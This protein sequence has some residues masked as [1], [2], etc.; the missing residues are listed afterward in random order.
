MKEIYVRTKLVNGTYMYAPKGTKD[1]YG[2]V[3]IDNDT[4]KYD[5]NNKLKVNVSV[6]NQEVN[7]E[8]QNEIDK[9]L[10]KTAVVQT[11]GDSTDKVM[12]QKAATDNF[13][14]LVNGKVPASQLPSYVDDVVEYDSKSAFPAEGETGKIYVDKSTNLTYRWSNSN[15]Y[16]MIGG[17]DLNLENGTG[18]GSLVQKRLKSDGVTWTT[19]KAYQGAGAAF[20]GNTQSGRTEEEFN[21]YFWDSTKN[22]ALNGGKGKDSNGNILDSNGLTYAKSYSYALAEGE[23]TKA[24]GRSSHAEGNATQ[25]IGDHSHSEGL[26]TKAEG[27]AAHTEGA[28]TEAYYTGSHAEGNHTKTYA[29]YQH[30]GGT[31]NHYNI[32]ALYQ[33]GN[34][35][36]DNDRKNAFEVLKDGRAKVYGTPQ[37]PTD[38]VRKQ[39]LDKAKDDFN[40]KNGTGTKSVEQV[41][42]NGTTTIPISTK[43]PNA[44]TLGAPESVNIGAVGEST[45]VFGGASNATGK[46][47]HAEGTNTVAIGKY[48]HAEGDNSVALGN[49]SHAE[50]ITTVAK[51]QASHSEGSTTQSIGDHSHAEGSETISSGYSSHS[52]GGNTQASG[53]TAHAEGSNTIASGAASHAEGSST[54]ATIDQAHAEG[55]ETKAS[56]T[57]SHSEGVS[58]TS[59]GDYSHAEGYKSTT[60]KTAYTLPSGTESG[61]GITGDAGDTGSSW[62]IEQHRGEGAHSEGILTQ[63]SGYSSHSEGVRTV[64]D[65]HYSHAE[66]QLTYAKGSSSHAEGLQTNAEGV[67]SHAEGSITKATGSSSHAEG[68]ETTASIDYAHAEGNVTVASGTASHAEG[69][70]TTASHVAAHAEGKYTEAKHEASHAEG[71]NTKTSRPSQH[72]EGKYNADNINALHIVGNGTSDTDRK[73]AF[74]V[75]TDGRAKVQSAPVESDDVVRKGDLSGVSKIYMHKIS[76][77][78]S[79]VKSGNFI[80]YSTNSTAYSSISSLPTM[81]VVGYINFPENKGVVKYNYFN[82]EPILSVSGVVFDSETNEYKFMSSISIMPTNIMDTVTEL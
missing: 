36:S 61:S 34:G 23:S 5:D 70:T 66:G 51:G 42:N 54:Q 44:V 37:E 2:T 33:V 17:G 30:V 76:F 13:A 59:E 64:A 35:T 74:T 15:N 75:L 18:T 55:L 31:Y 39:D 21:A 38:V 57:A 8:L 46:R 1:T 7:K 16:I 3:L 12:S 29:P 53:L 50:G 73:N 63:S 60:K 4:L 80:F 72:V 20:G 28:Y 79:S 40:L 19:A 67:A 10:D 47:S 56:G 22:V 32:N 62:N 14:S 24:L 49:D 41:I 82:P 52:E 65:G 25:S 68:Y 69:F 77:S 71:Q 26:S 45:S 6:I 11:T 81:D 43:N 27:Y 9:K 78:V 58:S 48:S